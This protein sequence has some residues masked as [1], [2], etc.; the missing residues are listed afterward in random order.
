M[1]I[2]RPAL[3]TLLGSVASVV[4]KR[5]TAPVLGTVLLS[6]DGGTLTAT[7]TNKAITVTDSAP[8]SGAL[9]SICVDPV[10][11]ISQVKAAGGDVVSVEPGRAG[12]IVVKAGR[13]TTT[14]NVH[15][16]DD[17]PHSPDRKWSAPMG[18]DAAAL[19][20]CIESVKHSIAGEDNKYGLSGVHL[21]SVT[22]D[23]GAWLRLVSTDGNRLSYDEVQVTAGELPRLGKVLMPRACVAEIQAHA[24]GAAEGAGVEIAFAE[25]AVQVRVGSATIVG[26][27]L[28]ADFPDY[29]QAVP[30]SYSRCVIVD[31]AELVAGVQGVSSLATGS[32]RT[33]RMD[34]REEEIGL[35][36]RKLDAGSAE[37]SSPCKATGGDIK[38]GMNASFLLETL[39]RLPAG[40]VRMDLTEKLSPVLVSSETSRARFVL[41][42]VR[43]D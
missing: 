17:F 21:E 10:V 3:L 32:T 20:R 40:E 36:A 8:C 16:G 34:I 1:N 22:G 37:S 14:L 4:D 31:R 43:L 39:A 19:A 7:A 26:L 2:P 24:A 25:R 29:R 15:P 33:L 28:E 11:L 23:D 12:Q 18:I 30:T 9:A 5:P 6:S 35:F 42:P 41:M 13:T 38:I 27:L